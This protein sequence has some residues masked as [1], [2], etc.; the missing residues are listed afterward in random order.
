M[1]SPPFLRYLV[2]P[3]SKYSPQHLMSIKQRFKRYWR[4]WMKWREA[5]WSDVMIFG[6]MFVLS[7]IY[8]NV[9][10]RRFCVVRFLIIIFFS[11]LFSNYSTY[12]FKYFLI[13]FLLVSCFAF[14]F[15]ILCTLCFCIFLYCFVYCF[16]CWAV[17]FL[18]LYKSTDH[19]QRLETQLQ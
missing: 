13:F 11:L 10:V 5:K 7:F 6:E 18:F 15:S 4:C 19:F 1:Q 8:C 17:S 12:V 14:L 9:A 3:R 2:P 16:S